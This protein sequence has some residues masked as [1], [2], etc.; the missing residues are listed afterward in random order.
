VDTDNWAESITYFDGLGR[1]YKTEEINS[2]GNIFAEKEFDPDGRVLRVSNPYRTGETKKWTTNV[3]DEAS[4][5]KEVILQDGAKVKTDYGVSVSGVIGVTKTITDQA[6]KKRM[7]YSDALG[8]MV[9]VV[10]DP[11]G[12]D[13]N[14]KDL[15]TD[16]VFDTLGNLRKTIQGEQSRYF[17]FDSLGRLLYSKQPEQNANT[18]FSYTD[19]VTS[20]SQWSVKYEYDDNGNITRTT[21]ARGVY[22]DGTYDN[23]N[24]LKSRS[25]SDDTPDVTFWYDGKGLTSV[26]DYS[27]GKTTR[28][29]SSESE[30]RYTSFNYF[31]QLVASEQRTPF[32]TESAEN[33]EPRV[34]SYE[35]DAFGRLLSQTYPSG[36]KVEFDYNQDGDI[37]SIWGTANGQNRLYLNGI[38]Y[39]AA[40]QM[41]RLRLGNGKWE[42]TVF[43]SRLQ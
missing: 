23:F 17:T 3:Y 34:S 16:Y 13:I 12:Q 10:E 37:S 9:R 22:V 20:N 41:T 43:N 24:R 7:G 32:G 6:G 4:R 11:G 31:G 1:A 29:A 26:P 18:A 42:S 27:K 15:A 35:Y 30:T 39:N 38:T 36:R 5:V 28:V 2:E 21:D 14:T 33:A 19:P 40:G 25:Y 8:R